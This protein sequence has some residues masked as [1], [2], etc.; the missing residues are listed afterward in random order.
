MP[1]VDLRLEAR[2]M[3]AGRRAAPLALHP[4]ALARIVAVARADG[5][6]VREVEASVEA[7]RGASSMV[8]ASGGVAV[9]PLKGVI[10]PAG[11][12]LS[13][14]FGDGAAG[15]RGFRLGLRE[16][17]GSEDVSAIVLDV[18]SPGGLVD[19]V[20]ET[21]AEVRAARAQKPVVAVANTFA[22]SAAYWIASQADE[23]VVTPSGDVGSIGVY[24]AHEDWSGFEAQLGVVTTLVSAGRFKV[25]G[26]PYAPLDDQA[27]AAMQE[28][29]DEVYSTFVEDVAAGRGATAQAVRDGYG[30]GRVLPA[31]RAV[32][33]GLA[34]EVATLEATVAR[35]A[36]GGGAPPRRA[37]LPAPSPQATA[38]ATPESVAAALAAVGELRPP[39]TL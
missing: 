28:T 19:L 11:S 26:N 34:D 14:L 35:M 30:E 38:Q 31:A 13:M 9:L 20:T 21:A 16:A 8:V 32:A 23:L 27:R 33:A 1:D 22:A 36:R 15:L 5:P 4:S 12:F 18:D 6:V 24:T 7:R 39:I 2:A 10:T 37:E 25:E 29:I 3:L 17:L